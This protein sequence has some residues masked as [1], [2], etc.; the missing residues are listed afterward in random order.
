[1][2]S[3]FKSFLSSVYKFGVVYTL[4]YRCFYVCPDWTTELPFLKTIF[5]KNSDP[6]NFVGK[7]FKKIVDNIHL[8]KEKVP[9]MEKK[10]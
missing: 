4:V 6:E 8:V 1:M 9:T 3:N 10:R 7:Y 2:Y 5:R